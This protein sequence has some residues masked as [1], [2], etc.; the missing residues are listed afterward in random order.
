MY[1][2]EFWYLDKHEWKK[3]SHKLY[4]SE[5][6][7]KTYWEYHYKDLNYWSNNDRKMIGYYM[8]KKIKEIII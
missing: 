4:D 6:S 7:F 3:S 5:K 2:I 8:N 1:K